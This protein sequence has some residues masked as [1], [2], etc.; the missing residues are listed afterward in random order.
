[1]PYGFG[2]FIVSHWYILTV[3][4]KINC[5]LVCTYYTIHNLQ[6]S[7]FVG[8]EKSV[9]SINNNK[10]SGSGLSLWKTA[11]FGSKKENRPQSKQNKSKYRKSKKSKKKGVKARLK[12]KKN[13]VKKLK[14]Q[15]LKKTIKSLQKELK[16]FNRISKSRKLKI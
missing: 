14:Q 1:M 7:T 13:E 3:T 8:K 6:N 2:R 5:L 15:D 4:I 11:K 9:I 16:K 10:E 12:K